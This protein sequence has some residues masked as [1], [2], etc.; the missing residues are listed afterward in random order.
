[1]GSETVRLRFPRLLDDAGNG[2]LV[3]FSENVTGIIG[4]PFFSTQG[5]G[6]QD[7]AERTLVL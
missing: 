6:D 2:S 7:H 4:R 3:S 1:M 5:P